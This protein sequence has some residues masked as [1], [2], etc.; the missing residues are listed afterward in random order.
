MRE[1]LSGNS[2]PGGTRPLLRE[3]SLSCLFPHVPHFIQH[4]WAPRWAQTLTPE[5]Y[6]L[7]WHLSAGSCYGLENSP[8]KACASKSIMLLGVLGPLIESRGRGWLTGGLPLR[9]TLGTQSYS[10]FV[11]WMLCEGLPI[12]QTLALMSLLPTGPVQQSQ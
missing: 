4:D 8:Q 2:C 3:D 1:F 9:S 5:W 6:G 12:A 10:C 11:S 7:P